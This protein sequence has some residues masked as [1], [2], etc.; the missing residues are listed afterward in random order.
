MANNYRQKQAL[1]GPASEGEVMECF[2]QLMLSPD[3]DV[4][5]INLPMDSATVEFYQRNFP[6]ED[7]REMVRRFVIDALSGW[8]VKPADAPIVR[9]D[10][11]DKAL[12]LSRGESNNGGY[13]YDNNDQ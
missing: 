9:E 11:A 3:A 10:V 8:Y 7:D 1:D 13:S 4:D 5:L 12:Y 6:F 2:Q